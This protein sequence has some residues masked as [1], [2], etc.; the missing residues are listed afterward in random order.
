MDN[1]QLS[2]SLIERNLT[3][4]ARRLR[5]A[6]IKVGTGHVMEMLHALE[7]V[8]PEHRSDVEAAMQSIAVYRPDQI[9]VFQHEFDQFWRDVMRARPPLIDRHAPP[10]D[11][12]NSQPPQEQHDPQD[13]K[14]S[15]EESGDESEETSISISADDVADEQI[16]NEDVDAPPQDVIMFSAEEALRKKDFG[17]FTPDELAMARRLMNRI[18]WNLGTRKTRRMERAHKGESF[19]Q[20]AMLRGSLRQGGIPLELRYRR[21]KEKMRPLVLICDISGSMDRYA[22]TLLQFV[23]TLETGL[24]SVEVFVFSTRLTR[25]TRELRKRDVDQ[26][27]NDVVA[28]VDDWSGGTRIGEAIRDFN[29]RWS[30]RVLRSNATVVL[31]S[32]GWDRGDPVLLGEEMA[33]LQRSC[34]R[35]I[36]LNPLLGASGYQPLTQGIKAA[37]PYVDYFMPI[38]NLQSLEALADL[39]GSVDDAP[40]LR[41]QQGAET[42]RH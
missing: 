26:A 5:R 37:L 34:R 19:D 36:W 16:D 14:Q 20:R 22:R 40:P 39:L 23:H 13:R 18:T 11:S 24:D 31:I 35:L 41:R 9:P 32:D 27:I 15:D 12:S 1:T 42:F 33:R 7:V 30:R 28:A 2:A 10:D 6:G 29:F 8:G 25:I 17:Q 38:H 3:H 21:R 4:F